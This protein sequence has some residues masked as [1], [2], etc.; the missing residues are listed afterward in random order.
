MTAVEKSM[1]MFCLQ[2]L[3]ASAEAPRSFL[4]TG[5]VGKLPTEGDLG[6]DFSHL[7]VILVSF[8]APAAVACWGDPGAELKAFAMCLV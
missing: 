4:P 6:L 7:A 8:L 1:G 2:I 5:W 3:S